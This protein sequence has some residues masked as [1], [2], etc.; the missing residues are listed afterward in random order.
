MY[1]SIRDKKN[2]STEIIEKKISFLNWPKLPISDQI[3][4]SPYNVNIYDWY[5]QMSIQKI[6]HY[7]CKGCCLMN[8]KT[9]NTNDKMTVHILKI[10]NDKA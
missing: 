10:C 5:I 6:I 8:N 1:S 4:I 2:C 9:L 7:K 3:H